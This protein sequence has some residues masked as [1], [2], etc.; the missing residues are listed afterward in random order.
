MCGMYARNVAPGTDK[1][2]KLNILDTRAAKQWISCGLKQS[3]ADPCLYF[4]DTDGECEMVAEVR[5]SSSNISDVQSHWTA[6]KKIA[7]YVSRTKATRLVHNGGSKGV[8]VPL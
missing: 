5:R 2:E 6:A 7:C 8:V 1:R 4:I 3:T